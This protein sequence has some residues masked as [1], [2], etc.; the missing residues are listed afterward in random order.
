[1]TSASEGLAPTPQILGGKVAD[2]FGLRR[3]LQPSML[4]LAELTESTGP[5]AGTMR[6][7]AAVRSRRMVSGEDR[8]ALASK[9]SPSALST[10]RFRAGK[11]ES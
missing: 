11:R 1:M 9:Y 4:F 2:L 6:L 7:H 5:K 3:V 8:T 10:V